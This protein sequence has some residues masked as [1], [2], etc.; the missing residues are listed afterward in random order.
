MTRSHTFSRALR[1][2]HAFALSF[3]WS[4]G[5]SASLG[6][7]QS[8]NVGFGFKTLDVQLKTALPKSDHQPALE[9]SIHEL[10][11]VFVALYIVLSLP[12]TVDLFR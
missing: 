8:N 7:G 4:T 5:S 2:L 9:R 6:I 3:D 10:H 1:E 12:F 11:W